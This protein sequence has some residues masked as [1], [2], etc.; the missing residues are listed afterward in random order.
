MHRAKLRVL[1]QEYDVL[2]CNLLE[3]LDCGGL[4][5]AHRQWRMTL[6]TVGIQHTF[7]SMRPM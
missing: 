2:F 1:K 7:E 5:P 6:D 4:E 3:G